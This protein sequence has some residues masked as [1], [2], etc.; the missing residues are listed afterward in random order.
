MLDVFEAVARTL[1]EAKVLDLCENVML[2]E[3]VEELV[4][5]SSS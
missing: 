2:Y 1:A 4:V 5:P 3:V